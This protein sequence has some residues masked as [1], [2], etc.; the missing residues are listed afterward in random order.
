M[1]NSLA[2]DLATWLIDMHRG[3]VESSSGRRTPRRSASRATGQRG[4]AACPASNRESGATRTTLSSSPTCR[5]R[6]SG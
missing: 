4:P 6:R 3:D 5:E 2:P 1:T